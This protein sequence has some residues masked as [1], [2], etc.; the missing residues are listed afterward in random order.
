MSEQ[1]CLK[2][3]TGSCGCAVG[4]CGMD[5]RANPVKV[6]PTMR[7]QSLETRIAALESTVAKYEARMLR[8]ATCA[9]EFAREACNAQSKDEPTTS[10]H[11]DDKAI[12]RF[13]NAM[14]TEMANRRARGR[15]GW[16]NKDE[17]ETRALQ[18]ML[19]NCLVKGNPVHVGNLAILYGSEWKFKNQG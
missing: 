19:L 2:R 13:A 10:E 16:D 9:G 3:N 12:D 14:K 1:G 7:P 6:P 8:M 5:A 18:E 4:C 15:G 11:P 17:C